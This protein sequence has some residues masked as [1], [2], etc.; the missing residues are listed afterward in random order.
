MSEMGFPNLFLKWIFA[1]LTTVSY[2][3]LINGRPCIP[4]PAKKGL[5]Q[6]LPRLSP[7]LICDRDGISYKAHAAVAQTT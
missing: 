2:S 1:C 6:G 3:I 7:F 5:R 4:F